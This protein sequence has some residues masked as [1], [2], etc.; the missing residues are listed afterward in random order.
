VILLELLQE[1]LPSRHLVLDVYSP[2]IFAAPVAALDIDEVSVAANNDRNHGAGGVAEHEESLL[3][4]FKYTARA[5]VGEEDGL[6]DE[7]AEEFEGGLPDA[8]GLGERGLDD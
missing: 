2:L 7:G 3:G 8:A 4:E 6:G 1:P 5:L